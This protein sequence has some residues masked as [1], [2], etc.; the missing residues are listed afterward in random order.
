NIFCGGAES[1][2][3]PPKWVRSKG[4]VIEEKQATSTAGP[5][6]GLREAKRQTDGEIGRA[7]GG[8][9]GEVSGGGGSF[10]KKKKQKKQQA[11]AHRIPP[12]KPHAYLVT[13]HQK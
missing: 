2:G 13:A 7:A 12:N 1:A 5:L 6:I 11:R 9:R 10:K 8:G 3:V 4:G